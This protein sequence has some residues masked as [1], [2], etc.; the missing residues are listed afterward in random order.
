MLGKGHFWIALGVVAFVAIL[1]AFSVY[2]YWRHMQERYDWKLGQSVFLLRFQTDLKPGQQIDVDHDLA[3]MAVPRYVA[4]GLADVVVVENQSETRA[5]RA[6]P[7]TRRVYKGMFLTTSMFTS[8]PSISLPIPVSETGVRLNLPGS[9]VNLVA[10]VRSKEGKRVPVRVLYDVLVLAVEGPR[11]YAGDG[12]EANVSL[13]YGFVTVEVPAEA[14][15][16]L[17]KVLASLIDPMGLEGLR[18]DG[19]RSGNSGRV[20]PDVLKMLEET[21]RRPPG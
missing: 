15:P 20:N 3:A 13:P 2:G 9:R 11:E 17:L 6:L 1:S 8:P 14:C 18:S 21:G 12:N 10:S 16:D 19:P 4:D 5:F 7:V